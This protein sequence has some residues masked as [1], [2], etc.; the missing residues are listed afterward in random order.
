MRNIRNNSKSHRDIIS[1][2][3]TPG[4]ESFI[5]RK[6]HGNKIIIE[7]INM[8][9]V[10]YSENGD[11][12]NENPVNLPLQPSNNKISKIIETIKEWQ[13]SIIFGIVSIVSIGGISMRV[14][15]RFVKILPE[16][17]VNIFFYIGIITLVILIFKLIRK[18]NK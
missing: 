17:L 9:E 15:N 7:S 3:P 18:R 11:I 5:R 6:K 4:K 1:F 16:I 13:E 12:N 10:E 8:D 2:T 14:I